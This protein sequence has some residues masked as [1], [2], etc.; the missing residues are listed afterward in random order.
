MKS[1]LNEKRINIRET[2]GGG[3]GEGEGQG[4]RVPRATWPPTGL[5]LGHAR[6][7]LGSGSR[8]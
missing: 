8:D 1:P 2:K 3:E 6:C 4:R 5:V 7:K